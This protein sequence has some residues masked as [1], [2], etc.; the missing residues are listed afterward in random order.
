MISGNVDHT[1]WIDLESSAGGCSRR[2]FLLQGIVVVKY[3]KFKIS[4]SQWNQCT[5]VLVAMK[6]KLYVEMYRSL[7]TRNCPRNRGHK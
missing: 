5:A 7:I 2:S 6:R 1:V 4:V 3:M